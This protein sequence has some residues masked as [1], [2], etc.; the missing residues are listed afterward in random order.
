M[1]AVDEGGAPVQPQTAASPARTW[2]WILFALVV[3]GSIAVGITAVPILA[4]LLFPPAIDQAPFTTLRTHVNPVHGVDEWTYTASGDAC[5]VFR[6]FEGQGGVCRVTAGEA[7][8]DLSDPSAP[9]GAVVDFV[10]DGSIDFSSFRM[11]WRAELRGTDL[12]VHRAVDW[13]GQSRTPTPGGG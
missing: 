5:T 4:G 2:L 13:T 6:H 9:P 3:V 10:C 1:A 8:C 12:V 7:T 11:N